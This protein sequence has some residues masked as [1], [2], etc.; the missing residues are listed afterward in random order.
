MS[1]SLHLFFWYRVVRFSLCPQRLRCQ[2]LF[3][4][5]KMF[6][7]VKTSHGYPGPIVF[8]VKAA[9]PL[10]DRDLLKFALEITN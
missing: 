10:L 4:M 7:A 8:T 3:K 1:Q 5:F 6:K 2:S 9:A